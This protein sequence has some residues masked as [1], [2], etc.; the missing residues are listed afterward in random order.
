MDSSIPPGPRAIDSKPSVTCENGNTHITDQ[1]NYQHQHSI[2]KNDHSLCDSSPTDINGNT[3]TDAVS[4]SSH[5]NVLLSVSSTTPASLQG[6]PTIQDINDAR[7]C[8]NNNNSQQSELQHEHVQVSIQTPQHTASSTSLFQLS[9][10]PSTRKRPREPTSSTI[11]WH[12]LHMSRAVSLKSGSSSIFIPSYTKVIYLSQDYCRWCGFN[13]ICPFV[14][15]NGKEP[16][17]CGD[18]LCNYDH[19]T[20]CRRQMNIP[21]LFKY[22]NTKVKI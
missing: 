16:C 21:Y 4:P 22:N 10:Q 8:N 14:S 15:S 9:A 7:H 3:T 20:F 19:T 13:E 1:H 11:S 18:I 5:S 2:A 6:P 17:P 12:T